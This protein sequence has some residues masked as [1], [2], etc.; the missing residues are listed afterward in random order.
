MCLAH[1]QGKDVNVQV[2]PDINMARVPEADS[3]W[4]DFGEVRYF[5]GVMGQIT[6]EGVLRKK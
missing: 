2:G 5:T 3:N 1:L 4:K 6:I